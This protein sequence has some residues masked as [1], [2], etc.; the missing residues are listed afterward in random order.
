MISTLQP[1]EGSAVVIAFYK[2]ISGKIDENVS[3]KEFFGKSEKMEQFFKD[4][5]VLLYLRFG[6]WTEAGRIGALTRNREFF[7]M[8]AMI[9]SSKTCEKKTC[10]KIFTC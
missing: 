9:I 6:E 7:D 10:L 5:E 4:K 1:T 8:R 3:P 2:D